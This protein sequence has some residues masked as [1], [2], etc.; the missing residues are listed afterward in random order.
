MKQHLKSAVLLAAVGVLGV[1][2][3]FTGVLDVMWSA[4]STWT[5][6][7]ILTIVVC[8]AWCVVAA[9]RDQR[10]VVRG[11]ALCPALGLLGTA[12]GVSLELQAI[13]TDADI[14]NAVSALGS[15]FAATVTGIGSAIVIY[16][17]GIALGSEEGA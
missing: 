17:Q 14:V 8:C 7:I 11:L 6:A 16:L 9:M 1:L 10:W 15:A 12:L 5:H 3:W 13:H 2:A 4:Q